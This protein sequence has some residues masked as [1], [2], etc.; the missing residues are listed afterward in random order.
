MKHRPEK[1]S[2]PAKPIPHVYWCYETEE[3]TEHK[4]SNKVNEVTALIIGA[5]R[6]PS[7]IIGLLAG[8][9]FNHLVFRP[10]FFK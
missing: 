1:F 7:F 4:T 6:R 3:P 9:L 10:L 2:R 5:F 8:Y